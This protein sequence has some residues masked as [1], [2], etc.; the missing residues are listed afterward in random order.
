MD[1]VSDELLKTFSDY[2]TK[3][4]DMVEKDLPRLKPIVLT[5][6]DTAKKAAKDSIL[7]EDIIDNALR[8]VNQMTDRAAAID[9]VINI[10]SSSAANT[11]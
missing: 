7:E 9:N 6:V 5:A 3:F 1:G 2:K 4:I 11:T 8:N 10:A